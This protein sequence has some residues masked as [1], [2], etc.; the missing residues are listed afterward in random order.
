MSTHAIYD[1][2]LE[3]LIAIT[4]DEHSEKFLPKEFTVFLEKDEYLAFQKGLTRADNGLPQDDPKWFKM[5]MLDYC[6]TFQ[7][8]P[9]SNAVDAEPLH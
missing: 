3:E 2:V 9:D 1:A 6:V 7:V 8:Q 5:N 4:E